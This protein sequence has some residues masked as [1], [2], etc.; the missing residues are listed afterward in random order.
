VK[1]HPVK[2]P[3]PGSYA[4]AILAKEVTH[5]A[6]FRRAPGAV[7]K[8]VQQGVA[9]FVQNPAF[10]GPKARHGKPL[11]P[12][13]AKQQAIQA[14]NHKQRQQ[15]QQKQAGGGGSG[16][17][18][19]AAAAAVAAAGGEAAAAEGDAP[20]QQQQQQQQEEGGDW[21]EELDELYADD[22]AA[23]RGHKRQRRQL[24]GRTA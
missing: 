2:P 9:R 3:E 1:A 14:A 18:A 12:E 6:D 23:G 5:T 16:G 20:T 15:Q 17:A 22:A 24:A 10:W 7:P 21:E 13:Q 19:A 4:A 11:G 8:S